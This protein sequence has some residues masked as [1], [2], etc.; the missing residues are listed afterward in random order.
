MPFTLSDSG[1]PRRSPAPSPVVPYQRDVLGESQAVKPGVETARMVNKTIRAGGSLARV[2]HANKIRRE[3]A[4]R[5]STWGITFRQNRRTSGC[6]AGTPRDRPR[7]YR[8]RPSPCRARQLAVVR[9]VS[10]RNRVWFIRLFPLYRRVGEETR[11][12]WLSASALYHS[13][14]GEG[15]GAVDQ[16]QPGDRRRAFFAACR[17]PTR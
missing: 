10:G 17:G 13:H 3:A 6:H 2:A 12:Y 15:A 4:A 7:Q 1:R 14:R 16:P 5:P 8:H 9:R 11:G